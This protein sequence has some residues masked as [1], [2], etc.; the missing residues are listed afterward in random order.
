MAGSTAGVATGRVGAAL[1][2][3]SEEMRFILCRMVVRL[4]QWF[5]EKDIYCNDW[6]EVIVLAGC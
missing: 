3:E 2:R 1:S 4:Q 5:P 6:N